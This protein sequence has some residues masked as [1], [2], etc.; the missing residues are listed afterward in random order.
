MNPRTEALKM[1]LQKR[2]EFRPALV[3]GKRPPANER[4]RIRPEDARMLYDRMK[5]GS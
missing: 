1:I 5:A 4:K 2:R 3:K